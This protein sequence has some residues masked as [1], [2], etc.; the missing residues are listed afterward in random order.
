MIPNIFAMLSFREQ[1][2]GDVWAT[3]VTRAPGVQGF[4][5]EITG[6]A[7]VVANAMVRLKLANPEDPTEKLQT[8]VVQYPVITL[9]QLEDK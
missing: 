7:D 6:V 2:N 9:I 8:E 5:I 3:H 4:D 1:R